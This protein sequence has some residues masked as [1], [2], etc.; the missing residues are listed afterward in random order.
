MIREC[1]TVFLGHKACASHWHNKAVMLVQP[2]SHRWRC[3]IHNGTCGKHWDSI[4]CVSDILFKGLTSCKMPVLWCCFLL[5]QF[6]I[7][8]LAF[9]PNKSI[10]HSCPGIWEDGREVS[11]R[12]GQIKDLD[13]EKWIKWNENYFLLKLI[14]FTHKKKT[15]LFFHS[16]H[17]VTRCGSRQM[18]PEL[19]T[20]SF[21]LSPDSGLQFLLQAS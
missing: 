4:L 10:N 15:V 20:G 6:E 21:R 9:H 8:V 11:L 1:L 17:A 5:E 3:A 12:I 7:W 19:G 14:V 13:I 2:I 18:G 16:P